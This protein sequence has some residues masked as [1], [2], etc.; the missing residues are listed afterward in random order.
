ML[1]IDIYC[2][3]IFSII[4]LMTAIHETYMKLKVEEKV[5]TY[6]NVWYYVYI[7][8]DTYIY[9]LSKYIYIIYMLCIYIYIC[10]IYV[11]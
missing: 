10:Y 11:I 5:V 7:Y 8:I 9:I 2:S 6:S 3:R 1:N 4:H